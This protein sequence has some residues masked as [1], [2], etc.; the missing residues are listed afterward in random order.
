MLATPGPAPP[1]PAVFTRGTP[2]SCALVFEAEQQAVH[3]LS[4]LHPRHHDAYHGFPVVSPVSEVCVSAGIVMES[5]GGERAHRVVVKEITL[6]A[7]L[8]LVEW[9][10]KNTTF[11][12]VII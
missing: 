6:T 11:L 10:G 5:A 2:P 1:S 4:Y 7:C 9:K 8:A 12:L 3:N